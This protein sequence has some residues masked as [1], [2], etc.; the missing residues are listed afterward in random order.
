MISSIPK[1]L[2]FRVLVLFVLSMTHVSADYIELLEQLNLEKMYHVM[3][4]KELLLTFS[5]KTNSELIS[6][7]A[8]ETD[9]LAYKNGLDKQEMWALR[10]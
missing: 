9:I 8:C 5:S 4:P 1:T 10:S 6:N 7:E 2:S 3:G